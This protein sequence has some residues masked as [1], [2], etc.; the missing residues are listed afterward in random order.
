[1]G[2]CKSFLNRSRFC[3]EF[4]DEFCIKVRDVDFRRLFM[5][6]FTGFARND[7]CRDGIKHEALEIL[8]T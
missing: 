1:M 3:Y 4:L 6:D 2:L 7:D 8:K 5:F